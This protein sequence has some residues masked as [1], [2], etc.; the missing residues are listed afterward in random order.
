LRKEAAEAGGAASDKPGLGHGS[1]S[2]CWR[3]VQ[4]TEKN[5]DGL[6]EEARELRS[7]PGFRSLEPNRDG[8]SR[9]GA[10]AESHVNL[11]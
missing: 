7:A 1:L 2:F 8:G 11:L 10:L 4:G 6:S 3:V 9:N 5:F